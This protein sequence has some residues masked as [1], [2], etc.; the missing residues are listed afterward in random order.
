MTIVDI[1]VPQMGEGL[2]EVIV[3]RRL[4]EAGD[5]VARDEVIYSMETDK[6]DMDVECPYEGTLEE[7]LVEEGDVVAVG[8]AVARL[9]TEMAVPEGSPVPA[10]VRAPALPAETP[11][12]A[13]SPPPT[14]V[15]IPPRTRAYGRRLG[16][17]RE[18]MERIPASGSTLMPRDVDRFRATSE[19][20]AGEAA[21]EDTTPPPP[22]SYEDR[23]LAPQQRIFNSRLVRSAAAVV[24][25]TMVRHLSWP[26]FAAAVEASR[27]RFPQLACSDFEVF[28]YAVA[29]AA[30][31]RPRF[32]S[33]L[34][35]DDTVR[36]YRHVNLGIAVQ[37]PGGDLVTARLAAADDLDFPDFVAAVQEQV[38]RALES[39]DQVDASV[40][41]LLS[42]VSDHGIIDAIPVLVAPA[43]AVV[44]VGAPHG[45]D[46]AE[47]ANLGVTFDHRLINGVGA[48]DFLEE[49]IARVEELGAPEALDREAGQGSR[50]TVG[51]ALRAA[52]RDERESRLARL[53]A[54]QVAILTGQPRATI[55]FQEP[56][57]NLGLSSRTALDL[58]RRLGERLGISLPATLT[59]AHPSIEALAS[60][61]AERIAGPSAAAEPEATVTPPTGSAGDLLDSID[62]LSEEEAESLLASKLEPPE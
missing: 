1:V 53:A 18:Q 35:G 28:A 27:Q 22:A 5:S 34:I 32:R 56:L 55:S 42:F 6:A 17:S 45:A 14:K 11:T 21:P 44:F 31:A 19:T 4:K 30:G 50:E 54:E 7:W 61:L 46:G 16:L 2:R 15:L 20:P 10:L 33:T 3:R 47:V 43:V 40:Q 49:I 13:A 26:R 25:A 8:T 23:P 39:G 41:L 24:P 52:P 38:G 48:A 51:E 62:Q 60:H 59:W 9:H 58:T 12:P 29:R 36:R 57:R 37:Q